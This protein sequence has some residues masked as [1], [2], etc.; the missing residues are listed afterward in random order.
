PGEGGRGMA[1]RRTGKPGCGVSR[2]R[3]R[4]WP[5]V[6]CLVV[7]A[8]IALAA[9]PTRALAANPVPPFTQCPAVGV[10]TGCTILI[11]I[12]PD[13]SLTILSDP[14]QKPFDRGDD[15]LVGVVNNSG[16]SVPSI[17]I[18]SSTQAVFGFEKPGPDALCAFT[19]C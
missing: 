16:I 13:G 8:V 5:R 2:V 12:Q 1:V 15:T 4:A 3:G 10:D 11:V 7:A 19:L 9:Q 14:T 6:L 17:S 18:G